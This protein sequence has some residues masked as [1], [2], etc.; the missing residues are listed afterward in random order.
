MITIKA[1]AKQLTAAFA[2][3]EKEYREHP[4]RF[5]ARAD[6]LKRSARSHGG[7]LSNTLMAYL[8]SSCRS[9]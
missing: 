7:R 3:W 8:P 4:E 6:S 2:K 5:E 1:T 9:T